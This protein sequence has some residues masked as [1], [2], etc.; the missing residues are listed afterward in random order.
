MPERCIHISEGDAPGEISI[1]VKGPWLHTILFEIPVLAIVNEVYFR[2]T[3][4]NPDWEEGRQRLQSKMH[5]VLDAPALADFR[6]PGSRVHHAGADGA[7]LCRHQQRAAGQAA[8]SAAAG[9]DG[10]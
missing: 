7:A 2:N 10:P 5:L 3:R 6:A 4:K 8:R 9:H 1:E